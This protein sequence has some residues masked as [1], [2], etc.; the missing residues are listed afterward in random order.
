MKVDAWLLV[1]GG[2]VSVRGRLLGRCCDSSTISNVLFEGPG[3]RTS[4][5]CGSG[6]PAM[7]RDGE[8]LK[9]LVLAFALLRIQEDLLL[10]KFPCHTHRISSPPP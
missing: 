10:R 9:L 6:V 5:E 4:G 1:P 7:T 3:S 8:S 2:K